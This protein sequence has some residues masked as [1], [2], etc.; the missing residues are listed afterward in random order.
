MSFEMVQKIKMLFMDG[1]YE[2]S[3]LEIKSMTKISSDTDDNTESV[4]AIYKNGNIH[5]VE[6]KETDLFF[7]SHNITTKTVKMYE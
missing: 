7:G 2:L 3:I 6:I 1:G 4:Y 5:L